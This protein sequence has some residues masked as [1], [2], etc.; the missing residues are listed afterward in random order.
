[1]IKFIFAL[2]TVFACSANAA[3][4]AEEVPLDSINN[5]LLFDQWKARFEPLF[6]KRIDDA[7]PGAIASITVANTKKR[8][9]Y[10]LYT[11]STT[12]VP[13][14][15]MG[16]QADG[17]VLAV[18]NVVDPRKPMIIAIHGHEENPWGTWAPHLFG[19]GKWPLALVKAGYI[20][21]L[22][23]SMTH[24]PFSHITHALGGIGNG[25]GDVYGY[26]PIWVAMVS[27]GLDALPKVMP[28]LKHKGYAVFGVSAGALVGY[29]LMAYRPDIRAG[30]FA[31]GQQP[32]DFY[33][34]EYAAM[35]HE[36]CWDFP[37]ITSFTQVKALIAP[38]PVQFQLGRQDPWWPDQVPFPPQPKWFPGTSRDVLVDEIAGQLL[39]LKAIWK[40]NGNGIVEQYLHDGGH[41]LIP[42]AGMAFIKRA[43]Q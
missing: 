41:A 43:L 42:S 36:R 32:L 5:K 40:T 2:I 28:N 11:I 37:G 3:T 30:V 18:P 29:T 17:G 27:R 7:T 13:N 4:L 15:N 8:A 6:R 39:L 35:V 25:K 12:H 10:T 22:P 34:R 1:M 20:V 33:R 16:G 21:W 31:G 23:V 24:A 38:R 9:G 26:I 19:A 14:Y